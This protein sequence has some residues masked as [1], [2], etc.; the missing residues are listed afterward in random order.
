MN[1][2]FSIEGK[3]KLG[4]IERVG[5]TYIKK[6]SNTPIKIKPICIKDKGKVGKGLKLFTIPDYDVGLL[7]HFG[8]KLSKSHNERV[9]ALKRALKQFSWLKI[10]QHINALRTLQK[11]NKKMYNK[12]DRDLKWLQKHSNKN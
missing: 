8:Y 9:I 7:S 1:T 6:S 12:L 4:E 10:L 3:C 11:S 2:K 5:Y